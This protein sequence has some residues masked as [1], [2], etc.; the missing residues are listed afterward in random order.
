MLCCWEEEIREIVK[1]VCREIIYVL[2][3]EMIQWKL[4]P[5]KCRG[6][7]SMLR[8]LSKENAN[9]FVLVLDLRFAI[10]NYA[11]RNLLHAFAAWCLL[12]ECDRGR[13]L[14][15]RYGSV[16]VAMVAVDLVLR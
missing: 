6:M 4:E 2:A 5:N 8:R 11:E 10:V 14:G 13:T 9:P 7:W 3:T 15:R 12:G 16:L 1:S